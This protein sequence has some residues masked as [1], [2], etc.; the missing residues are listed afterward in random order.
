MFKLPDNVKVIAVPVPNKKYGITTPLEAIVH[1]ATAPRYPT[2]ANVVVADKVI[3]PET[4]RLTF[5]VIVP[6]QPVVVN[7][8]Q[9]PLVVETGQAFALPASKMTASAAVGMTPADAPLLLTVLQD[10]VSFQAVPTFLK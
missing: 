7:V 5:N 8:K 9:T 6:V 10:E 2:P 4:R 3:L 1:V